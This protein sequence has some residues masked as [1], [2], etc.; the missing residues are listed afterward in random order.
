MPKRK[1]KAAPGES[2]YDKDYSQDPNVHRPTTKAPEK[3]KAGEAK[4]EGKEDVATSPEVSLRENA[5]NSD[6]NLA[7]PLK[8][9]VSPTDAIEKVETLLQ[10]VK[11][12]RPDLQ[13][14]VD[15]ILEQVNQMEEKAL[16]GQFEEHEEA[17]A[18][19]P[20]EMEPGSEEDQELSPG[21]SVEVQTEEE[22]YR[23]ILVDMNEDGTWD[24]QTDQNMVLSAVPPEA[25]RVV[26]AETFMQLPASL[27]ILQM[28]IKGLSGV[29]LEQFLQEKSP[30]ELDSLVHQWKDRVA[31]V[32]TA[33]Q[34]PEFIENAI[35]KAEELRDAKHL[36]VAAAGAPGSFDQT[37]EDVKKE[38]EELAKLG[39]AG[40]A[41]AL[42]KLVSGEFDEDISQ[43]SDSRVSEI[44]DLL[45]DL[46]MTASEREKKMKIKAEVEAGYAETP[47]KVIEEKGAVRLFDPNTDDTQPLTIY[48]NGDG[49]LAAMAADGSVEYEDKANDD[50]EINFFK[51]V[52]GLMT[53]TET[54]A[55]PAPA[56][57]A[58]V[59][60]AASKI[61]ADGMVPEVF[62][63][64][65]VEITDTSGRISW[66]PEV[67]VDDPL[68]KSSVE[69]EVEEATAVHGWFGR[70][71]MPGY[72]DS[73]EWVFGETEEECRQD[74]EN[75]YGLEDQEGLEA[76]K[77]DASATKLGAG[78]SAITAASRADLK[79]RYK[80]LSIEKKGTTMKT[81]VA[82]A[83]APAEVTIEA[84]A[85]DKIPEL[86]LGDGFKVRRKAGEKKDK[87]KEVGAPEAPKAEAKPEAPAPLPGAAPA[88]PESPIPT[89]PKG[90]GAELVTAEFPPKDEK[91]VEKKEG[92][93]ALK[94]EKPKEE[95]P[96]DDKGLDKPKDKKDEKF[97]GPTLEIVDKDGKVVLADIP[98]AFGDD[99][100]AIIKFFQS[101]LPTL[102]KKDEKKDE[103]GEKKDDKK[104]GE[105]KKDKKEEGPSLEDKPKALPTVKVDKKDE[106]GMKAAQ[107][108]M[109]QRITMVRGVVKE[110]AAKRHIVADQKDIDTELMAQEKGKESLEAAMDAAFDRASE[111]K[112]R[113]ILAMPD[114]ELLT[115]RA[116]LP[117][118]EIK[119]T[120]LE[121]TAS[122]E[123]LEPLE[124]LTIQ[125]AKA[126]QAGEVSIGAAFGFSSFR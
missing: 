125:A 104:E 37:K 48:Q 57:E 119:A 25:I 1:L 2:P 82:A 46:S 105:E 76:K 50:V 43:A 17:E 56:A 67:G 96:K 26:Q 55:E 80:K 58:Q 121:I 19:V 36:P 94:D 60:V 30:E 44:V 64:D 65:G 75:N 35:H 112:F 54:P 77:K 90:I 45:C 4:E 92:E 14:E 70:Y 9:I 115:L 34:D 100:V 84:S 78:E 110:L 53:P 29:P 109:E 41:V 93:E 108:L 79:A 111:R 6:A 101:I 107:R 116:S 97:H 74:L 12:G 102:K 69:G 66:L 51:G 32:G 49:K 71:T 113:E 7:E 59:P 85:F 3:P 38:L 120:Q 95:G 98:D 126:A 103:K 20:G 13:Q 68:I 63:S 123:G 5:E 21:S 87:P 88:A 117:S 91:P 39:H 122:T 42:T 62:E 16:G 114:A 52:H 89:A 73:T 11:E 8:Y 15:S 40:A 27:Q 47:T 18:G 118:L 81:P 61:K 23:G 10:K 83:P 28:Q 24:V 99:T 33:L 22:V 106:E 86:D 31:E 72:L 124:I